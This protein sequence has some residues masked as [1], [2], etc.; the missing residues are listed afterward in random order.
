MGR[1]RKENNNLESKSVS[2][3]FP[4]LGETNEKKASTST[5]VKKNTDNSNKVSLF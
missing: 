5:D 3:H 2:S 1:K 4:L